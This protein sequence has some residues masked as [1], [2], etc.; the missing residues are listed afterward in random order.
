MEAKKIFIACLIGGIL[1]TATAIACS[2]AFWW[3]GM[4]AGF[5]GGY[6]AFEFRKVLQAIPIAWE[7]A[8]SFADKKLS[9]GWETVL[10]FLRGIRTELNA[11]HPFIYLGTILSLPGTAWV[12]VMVNNTLA[13]GAIS[14]SEDTLLLITTLA[15]AFVL[16]V[17][18]AGFIL[19]IGGLPIFLLTVLG[20]EK[21]KAYWL[22]KDDLKNPL[23]LEDFR[24]EM[25]NQGYVEREASYSNVALWTMTGIG[26][27]LHFLAVRLWLY[28][29]FFVAGIIGIAVRFVY[30]LIKLIHCDKRVLCGIDS[31]IGG[32]LSYWWFAHIDSP[33]KVA[34]VA[35][36]CFG[37]LLGGAL[38]VANWEIV[39][40]RVL[41]F[42]ERKLTW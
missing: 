34:I 3:V 19:W 30:F 42:P 31:L 38:G 35:F 23:A 15:F 37:G 17:T 21:G 28:A 22:T 39:S 1:C 32:T 7:R 9:D 5:A 6:L 20:A 13:T 18:T 33:S 14:V 12:T 10:K 4:L 16:S 11:P 40:K 27:V 29:F 41:H 24:K 26:V 36:V 2:P 8:T 25:S